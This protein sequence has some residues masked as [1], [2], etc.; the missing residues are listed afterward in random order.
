MDKTLDAKYEL[1]FNVS[2]FFQNNYIL[3]P[4]H[5]RKVGCIKSV[6]LLWASLLLHQMLYLKAGWDCVIV[7][8]SLWDKVGVSLL[9][10]ALTVTEGSKQAAGFSHC[11]LKA[12]YALK[13]TRKWVTKRKKNPHKYGFPSP[14][15]L[16]MF[17]YCEVLSSLWVEASCCFLKNFLPGICVRLGLVEAAFCNVTCCHIQGE[18][19]QLAIKW[20]TL[21]RW[22]EAFHCTGRSG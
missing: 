19:N 2:V 16:Y 1:I 3:L 10:M 8:H 4:C 12:T 5:S 11:T 14:L 15:S 20:Y 18:K 13:A 17:N 7:L 6:A 9:L 22:Q 21:W